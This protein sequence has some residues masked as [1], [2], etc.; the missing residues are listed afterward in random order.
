MTESMPRN[1]EEAAYTA[2]AIVDELVGLLVVRGVLDASVVHQMFESV[3]KRLAQDNN[4]ISQR[5][6]KFIADRMTQ[7][8]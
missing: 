1:S 2:Y 6:A 3:A 5:A 7:K 8:E 4:F